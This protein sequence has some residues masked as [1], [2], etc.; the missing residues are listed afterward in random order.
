MNISD[1]AGKKSDVDALRNEGI[2][3]GIWDDCYTTLDVE[4]VDHYL[5]EKIKGINKKRKSEEFAQALRQ[6]MSAKKN[7]TK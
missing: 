3:N 6:H 5:G 2:T 4:N 1:I 7:K